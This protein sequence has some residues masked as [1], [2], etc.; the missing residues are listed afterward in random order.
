MLI[1]IFRIYLTTMAIT[2]VSDMLVTARSQYYGISIKRGAALVAILSAAIPIAN[3]IVA[4]DNF[5]M[6]FNKKAKF[7]VRFMYVK[8]RLDEIRIVDD[9]GN[10]TG[11]NAKEELEKFMKGE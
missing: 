3:L 5:T 8:G 7:V 4:Y 11:T 10:D 9:D 2:L 1:T 6:L